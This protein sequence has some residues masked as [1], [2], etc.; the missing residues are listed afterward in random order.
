M[1]CVSLFIT[2]DGVSDVC[3]D[4]IEHECSND[5]CT[6]KVEHGYLVPPYT[7]SMQ[8]SISLGSNPSLTDCE[9]LIHVVP[10]CLP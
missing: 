8:A 3:P 6:E 7:T 1:R 2:I 4:D 9:F 5:R 10:I